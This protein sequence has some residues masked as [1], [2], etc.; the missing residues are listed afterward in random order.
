M[1]TAKKLALIA[2]GYALAVAGGLAA[3]AVNEH[4]CPFGSPH[5]TLMVITLG[6]CG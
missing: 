4:Q 5:L 1:T 6:R 3:V 2:A